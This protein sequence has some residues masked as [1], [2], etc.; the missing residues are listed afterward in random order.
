MFEGDQ[1]GHFLRP[2][3]QPDYIFTSIWNTW[4][5]IFSITSATQLYLPDIVN[6]NNDILVFA[7]MIFD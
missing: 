4:S 7:K 5:G 6:A 3:Q 2:F 1:L